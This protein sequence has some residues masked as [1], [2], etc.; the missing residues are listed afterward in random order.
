[1]GFSGLKGVRARGA[2]KALQVSN[3]TLSVII[4]LEKTLMKKL[5]GYKAAA[6]DPPPRLFNGRVPYHPSALIKYIN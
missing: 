6:R 3:Y 4:T 5:V 1:M 2:R